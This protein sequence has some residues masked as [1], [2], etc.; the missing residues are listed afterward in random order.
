LAYASVESDGFTLSSNSD[1]EADLRAALDV[2]EPAAEIF[3]DSESETSKI[4]PVADDAPK[5][6]PK[7]EAKPEKPE[8]ADKRSAQQRIDHVTWERE[9]ARRERDRLRDELASLKTAK[10]DAQKAKPQAAP[11][12]DPEPKEEDFDDYG[13]YVTEKAR[14]AARAEY[15]SQR[16][17][18]SERQ[19]T[20]QRERVVTE[21]HTKLRERLR[22]VMEAD[23]G[24]M[25]RVH[26]EVQAL[27]PSWV[28]PQGERATGANAM[29]DIMFDVE[30]PDAFMR[31]FTENHTEFR[32]IAALHP[33]QAVREMGRLEARLAPAPTGSGAKAPAISKA[34]PPVRPVTGSPSTAS[35][36]PPDP[37][38]DDLD[39]HIHFMRSRDKA[40]RFR[41]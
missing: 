30:H 14:H 34:N 15:R 40:G 19:D 6:E 11:D 3:E 4:E 7:V 28:L 31:Y 10:P 41:A 18:D 35:D 24:F 17:A 25:D 9:E 2:A 33:I 1:S 13:K 22:P 29:A 37:D 27:Q 5:A 23:P 32:R 39:A 20:E 8:A 38:S 26:P 16:Q 21:R 12:D 36:D